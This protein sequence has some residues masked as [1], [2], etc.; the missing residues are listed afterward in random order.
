MTNDFSGF[1]RVEE[2]F[3]DAQKTREST[4]GLGQLSLRRS[5][6]LVY[7]GEKSAVSTRTLSERLYRSGRVVFDL[8]SLHD[9]GN[10]L[11]M[12]SESKYGVMGMASG[13]AS[14]TAEIFREILEAIHEYR[15]PF[16]G[17]K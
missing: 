9:I 8:F 13:Q 6:D 15:E 1:T 14:M 2:S 3:I 4:S 5:L 7:P 11:G 10:V 12:G 17:R 16:C